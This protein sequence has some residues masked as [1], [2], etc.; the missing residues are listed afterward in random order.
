MLFNPHSNHMRK[1][2][3]PH[4]TEEIEKNLEKWTT[5]QGHHIVKV[6]QSSSCWTPFPYALATCTHR[7][8]SFS[9]LSSFSFSYS[10][11]C[12]WGLQTH[13]QVS[14]ELTVAEQGIC[15]PA[16]RKKG[17]HSPVLV[18]Q[19][20]TLAPGLIH[21]VC[22]CY[23]I[24]FYTFRS[25]LGSYRPPPPCTCTQARTHPG[26]EWCLCYHLWTRVDSLIFILPY[27]TIWDCVSARLQAFCVESSFDPQLKFKTLCSSVSILFLPRCSEVHS[28]L[29]FG[30]PSTLPCWHTP[31]DWL[32]YSIL[33]GNQGW[34]LNAVNEPIATLNL[35]ASR[36]SLHSGCPLI[37]PPRPGSH[38]VCEAR[39]NR[40][41]CSSLRHRICIRLSWRS[42]LA[43]RSFSSLNHG[44]K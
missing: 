42:P 5:F 36:C 18:P 20:T 38:Q 30:P 44:S 1:L 31:G 33:K 9:S 34:S 39:L 28:P 27:G 25:V 13:H 19:Q 22:C 6:L 37:P 12:F 4:F 15:A 32:Y 2:R 24:L 10:K 7:L 40:L 43:P 16:H 3:N 8:Q 29:N 14:W 21:L 35:R 41:Q 23:F 26:P 11:S 17:M